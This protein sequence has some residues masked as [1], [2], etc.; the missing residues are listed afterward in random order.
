MTRS[1]SAVYVDG[2]F[3]ELNFGVKMTEEHYPPLLGDGKGRYRVLV[4]GNSGKCGLSMTFFNSEVVNLQGQGRS[5][6]HSLV[7]CGIT[8]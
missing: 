2:F 5:K 6:P 3:G 4:V 7:L 8:H 1:L